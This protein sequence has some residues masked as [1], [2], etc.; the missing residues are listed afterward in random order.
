VQVTRSGEQVLMAGLPVD[1]TVSGGEAANDTLRIN[2]LG[3]DDDV[4]VAPGVAT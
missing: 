4:T 3:G 1:M 2:T